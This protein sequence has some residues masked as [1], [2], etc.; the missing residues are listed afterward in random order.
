MSL[1]P[2]LPTASGIK[3]FFSQLGKDVY[4]TSLTLFKIMIPAIIIVKI[5]Q[6]LGAIDLLAKF[7]EP[8]T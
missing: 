4:D 6:E 2:S 7:L 1:L 3:L 8:L 5:A